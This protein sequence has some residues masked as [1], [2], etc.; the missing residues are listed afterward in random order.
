MALE[1]LPSR[2]LL[3]E[4][5]EAEYPECCDSSLVHSALLGVWL[6]AV[7]SVLPPWIPIS[8]ETDMSPTSS[9][10]T[11]HTCRAVVLKWH[12]LKQLQGVLVEVWAPGNGSRDAGSA[13]LP[14]GLGTC[15]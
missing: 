6:L 1:L 8:H 13:N 3:P 5:G 14:Q 10:C 2:G 4:T 9:S 11:G 12:V 15:L 7:L